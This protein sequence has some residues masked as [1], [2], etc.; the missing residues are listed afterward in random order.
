[1]QA[2]LAETLESYLFE[3]RCR[4]GNPNQVDDHKIRVCL[5]LIMRTNFLINALYHLIYNNS[6]YV[7]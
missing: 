4:S 3:L 2:G 1:M 5:G 7:G 6:I